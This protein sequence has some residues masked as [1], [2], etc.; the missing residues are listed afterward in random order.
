[1]VLF[2]TKKTII[3][4][5]PRMSF[6]A[7]SIRGSGLSEVCS[8]ENP[9]IV[10]WEIRLNTLQQINDFTKATLCD[11]YLIHITFRTCFCPFSRF[12]DEKN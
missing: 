4:N 8:G 5:W 12:N 9:T 11:Q 1:M 7:G 10:R 6:C 2:G 3:K